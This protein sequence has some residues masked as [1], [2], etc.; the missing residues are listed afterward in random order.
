MGW[1][2]WFSLTL[3]LSS[4]LVL[5]FSRVPAHMVMLAALA[6]LSIT[7]ILSPAEAF[8]GF[9]NPGVITVVVMFILAAG[10]HTSGG[11]DLLVNRVLGRRPV[12]PWPVLFFRSWV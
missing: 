4:L 12:L 6:I 2:A 11:V 5:I 1:Q 7:G 3:V 8:A 9:S 10:I